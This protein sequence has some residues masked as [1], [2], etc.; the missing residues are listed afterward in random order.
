MKKNKSFF[1]LLFFDVHEFSAR[2]IPWSISSSSWHNVAGD[3][4][5]HLRWYLS[6]WPTILRV[7]WYCHKSILW[8]DWQI[9]C[10]FWLNNTSNRLNLPTTIHVPRSLPTGSNGLDTAV[11][12]NFGSLDIWNNS[13]TDLIVGWKLLVALWDARQLLVL[14]YLISIWIQSREA[15][16]FPL[17]NSWLLRFILCLVLVTSIDAQL[18]LLLRLRYGRIDGAVMCARDA[19]ARG[20]PLE[21]LPTAV[22]LNSAR[23]VLLVYGI[24]LVF[25]RVLIALNAWSVAFLANGEIFL[26]PSLDVR[27]NFRIPFSWSIRLHRC[28][29]VI[30][31]LLARNRRGFRHHRC[32]SLLGGRFFSDLD[33]R[34]R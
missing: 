11:F 23:S 26:T 18:Q 21:P 7:I 10:L 3:R 28:H 4:I 2:H 9:R 34:I 14:S 8:A 17:N 13:M 32:G 27:V 25:V 15:L 31:V 19:L 1:N 6:T 33:L 20:I 16:Y 22:R 5:L 30:H 24:L 12:I 29:R